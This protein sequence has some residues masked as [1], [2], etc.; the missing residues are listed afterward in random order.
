MDVRYRCK[1]LLM[2]LRARPFN[3]AE[4]EFVHQILNEKQAAL[5]FALPLYEQH[6][7]YRVCRMLWEE[8]HQTDTALLQAALLH[9]LGKRD[10]LSG[11]YISLWDKILVVALK[12]IGG[13]PLLY[14]VAK[15]DPSSW[16][17][18]FWLQT[19]HEQR[20]AELAEAVGSLPRVVALIA[21]CVPANDPAFVALKGADDAN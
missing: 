9:D 11:R 5:F 3:Q 21:G 7:A 10:P 1:Q 14:K 16:L 13:K 20:S 8:G 2:A 19:R 4:F 18:V 17:Y 12:K 6:H 15:P